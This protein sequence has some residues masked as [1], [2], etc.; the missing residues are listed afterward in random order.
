M[1][2]ADQLAPAGLV[3]IS[4][5]RRA[6]A[7]GT[8]RRVRE[9]AGVTLE[10]LG[11]ACGVEPQTVLRWENGSRSPRTAAAGRYAA[12]VVALVAT[13]GDDDPEVRRLK[14]ALGAA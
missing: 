4:L 14:V 12:A 5:V 6:A 2:V 1:T 13:L 3:A 8:A 11:R 9:L 10:E 7:D